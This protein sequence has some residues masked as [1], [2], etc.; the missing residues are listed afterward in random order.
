MV[1]P[2]RLEL[3]LMPTVRPF[4]MRMSSTVNPSRISAP[5]SSAASISDL[6][7]IVRRGAKATG[8]V[9]VPG[10]PEIVKGPK[11]KL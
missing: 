2:P 5:A 10:E 1:E 7:S 11:S 6:S 4:S 9:S 8:A 3:P